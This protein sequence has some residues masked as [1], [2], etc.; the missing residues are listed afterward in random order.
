[1]ELSQ[2]VEIVRRRWKAAVAAFLIVLGLGMAAAFLPATRY[3]AT[4][5]LL[6]QPNL[7]VVE[8]GQVQVVEFL[9]P[10]LARQAESDRFARSAADALPRGATRA[11]YDVTA[12]TDPGTGVLEI[13]VTT[14]RRAAAAPMANELAT[15]LVQRQ[16]AA[17]LVV[18]S[19]LD[20]ASEPRS[21]A[22]PAPSTIVMAAIVLGLIAAVFVA[23]ATNTLRKRVQG[24]EEVRGRFGT[25][26][27]GEIPRLRQLKKLQTR[28]SSIL[29]DT[30]QPAATEAFHRLRTN[31]ELALLSEGADAITVTSVSPGDG[32]STVVATL[33]W[34]LASAGHTVILVD[35]DLRRPTLHE[36]LGE[37]FGPG[38][39]AWA[40]SSNPPPSG[41]ALDELTFVPA[42]TP[43][44]HP[45]EVITV[46]LPKLLNDLERPGRLVMVDAP[47]LEGVAETNLIA[48]MTK[49]VILVVDARRHNPQA[50]ENA[51][52]R[53]HEAGTRVV[54]V[55]INRTKLSRAER[56]ISDYYGS[57]QERLVDRRA[58]K[59][60]S[61]VK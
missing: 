39:C 43:D 30:S 8:F 9:L 38:V 23:L 46:A 35:A 53:L 45:A 34:S 54:G 5:T 40:A 13:K 15:Q 55:V 37:P 60:K 26:V 33:G 44:R 10:S 32:K 19:V 61:T 12:E 58:S 51:M 4:A 22:P 48:A 52:Y 28:P 50:V 27:L 29:N 14:E 36:K 41:T 21:P 59:R 57:R 17:R 42:G 47:P 56:Q 6:A 11:S 3:T 16:A 31:M 25:S 49:A 24:A 20:P 1:M 18:L 7:E 2:L